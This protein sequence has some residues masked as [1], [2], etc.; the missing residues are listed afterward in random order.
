MKLAWIINTDALLYKLSFLKITFPALYVSSQKFKLC[1]LSSFFNISDCL[2]TLKSD[3]IWQWAIGHAVP[4]QYRTKAF[5]FTW[6]QNIIASRISLN[7]TNKV[8]LNYYN[9]YKIKLSSK[10]KKRRNYEI[11]SRL[12][13][14]PMSLYGDHLNSACFL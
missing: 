9:L 8:N 4:R 3:L 5:F 2:P 11:I 1:T 12:P 13:S 10:S 7:K 6:F 14:T